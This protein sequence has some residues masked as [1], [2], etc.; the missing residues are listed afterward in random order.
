MPYSSLPF[1]LIGVHPWNRIKPTSPTACF[2]SLQ[3]GWPTE[4]AVDDLLAC[5]YSRPDSKS[6]EAL[7]VNRDRYPFCHV[8]SAGQVALY[9]THAGYARQQSESEFVVAWFKLMPQPDTADLNVK[10]QNQAF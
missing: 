2:D 9:W 10:G 5:G 1:V 6:K 8:L 7:L 3:Q 4:A